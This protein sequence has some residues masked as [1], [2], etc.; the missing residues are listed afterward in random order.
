M[1]CTQC[2]SSG[3]DDFQL[4]RQPAHR[5][6]KRLRSKLDGLHALYPHRCGAL[7]LRGWNS[8][9]S[10]PL[11]LMLPVICRSYI[12]KVRFALS[13]GLTACVQT[14]RQSS[15]GKSSRKSHPAVRVCAHLHSCHLPGRLFRQQL[16]PPSA[17]TAH[18]QVAPRPQPPAER[19]QQHR[20]AAGW[21]AQ[22][23]RHAACE[24]RRGR[25]RKQMRR[26]IGGPSRSA[27]RPCMAGR[28]DESNM[29]VY[30][31]CVVCRQL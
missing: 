22:Q 13:T 10:M 31:H 6:K 19:L 24:A 2:H 17:E 27:M 28:A 1:H 16:Q 12:Q 7:T 25:T 29:S 21:R 30:Q 20:L 14:A 4:S 26:H 23:Q 3:G 15:R 18:P 9:S 11:Y 8:P 5:P